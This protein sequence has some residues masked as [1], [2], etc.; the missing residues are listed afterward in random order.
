MARLAFFT[1]RLPGTTAPRSPSETSAVSDTTGI[2]DFS[3]GLMMSLADQQHDV[4]VFSTYR[5]SDS[6]PASHPR[7]Q[8]IRPFRKWSWFEIPRLIPILLDFQPEI[9]HFIQPR[10]EAFSSLTNATSALP[11]LSPMIGRP[12]IV[13]SLYDVR[14]EELQR[15]KLL[16]A[17][18]D[19]VI[20]ANRQQADELGRWLVGQARQPTVEIVSLPS[21]ASDSNEME[22]DVLPGLDRLQAAAKELIFIPGDL[23]EQKDLETLAVVLNEILTSVPT[24]GVIF[25]GGWGRMSPQSRREFMRKFEERGNGARLL[26]TGPLSASGELTCL[27]AAKIA[28]LAGL[29]DSSLSLARLIRQAL[30]TSRPLVLSEEQCRLDPMKWRDRENAFIVSNET[31]SWARVLSEAILDESLRREI[32]ARLPSFARTEAV[33]EPGNAMSRIYAQV[34]RAPRKPLR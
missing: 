34:L 12:R 6:L 1:E 30:Q 13:V 23:D 3:Y 31:R 29:P 24:L 5:E 28:L 22:R 4:R 17:L 32:R 25:G 10:K 19:T 18:A 26:L 20:V 7:L 14:R 15:N 2:T 9:L 11:T 33:D 8:I 16:L 21:S 27:E